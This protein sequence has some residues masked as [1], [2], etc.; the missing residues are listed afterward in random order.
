M[1]LP[2]DLF[3]SGGTVWTGVPDEPFAEAVAVRSGRIVAVGAAAAVREHVGAARHSVD[4]KGKAVLPGFQDAHCHPVSGGLQARQ[5]DM[6]GTRSLADCE[7]AV[8][9]FLAGHPDAEWVTG[10]GWSMETF[11]GGTP[12]VAALDAVCQGRP[13]FLVN[14]DGH[15]AWVSSRALELAGIDSSTPDP[16][17]GRIEREVDGRPQGTLHEGAM[18][19][20][21]RLVPEPD[22]EELAAALEEAQ[23]HLLSL[24]VTGWQ[25]AMV[26]REVQS[27]YESL[28]GS[29]K[30]RARARLALWWERCPGLEQVADL[31]ERR[32]NL[33][34]LGL[35]AGTVKMMLDGVV[36]NHTAALLEPYLDGTS[37]GGCHPEHGSGHLFF[38]PE[39]VEAALGLLAP[40]GFQVH[41]HAIG[42]RAVRLALDAVEHAGDGRPD[43]RHHVA[44]IQLVHP[45]D[46]GRFSRLGVAANAQPFW[47]CAEP[48]MT[49]LTI[50]FL[51]EERSSWQ[52]PFAS[53]A[54]SGAVLAGGSD[55][56]VST[57]NPLEEIAVA[58]DRVLPERARDGAPAAE[59]FLPG[60]R[61][62]LARSLGAFTAGSAYV[63]HMER[64]TGTI[65]PGKMADLVVLAQDPF[66]IPIDHL[67]DAR[68]CLT[69]VGGEIAFDAGAV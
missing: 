50:P 44:H 17:D 48:Q 6:G 66:S 10:G 24:G 42:D 18:D 16:V 63:N 31:V 39:L 14:R 56:P 53:I 51:G 58:V 40:E 55:W 60:E 49:E 46:V 25:D 1:S 29:G 37:H 11:P 35:D 65:E 23:A 30:L 47:A 8:A 61:L 4:L 13:A 2:A 22:A 3:L 41:F 7:D 52:Y 12:P 36:E 33:A 62:D 68:V 64:E 27:A 20:V 19:L 54:R 5:C 59:P 26:D 32:A 38:E 67:P 21:A 69:V 57:A 45:D 15:G 43:L 34:T 9:R 28:A